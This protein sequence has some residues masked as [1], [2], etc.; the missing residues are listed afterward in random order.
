MTKRN[1]AKKEVVD[2]TVD[3]KSAGNLEIKTI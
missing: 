2:L 1:H 3:M